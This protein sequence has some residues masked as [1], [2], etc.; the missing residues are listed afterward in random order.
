[1]AENDM[2]ETHQ[3]IASALLLPLDGRIS[4]LNAVL[5]SVDQ[6][7]E[8]LTQSELDES[9]AEEIASR[10]KDID[11]GS[12]TTVSSSELWKKLGGKPNGDSP[13]RFL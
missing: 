13:V 5:E 7:A 6:P 3:I 9:W 2:P 11:S 1:M 4:L 10:V 12:V 8:K